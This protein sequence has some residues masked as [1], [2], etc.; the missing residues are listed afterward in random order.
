MSLL[1]VK[2]LNKKTYT[3]FIWSLFNAKKYRICT[4]INDLL[5]LLLNKRFMLDEM[6]RQKEKSSIRMGWMASI[7]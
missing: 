1:I 5:L 6:L 7:L 2:K 3:A 4:L